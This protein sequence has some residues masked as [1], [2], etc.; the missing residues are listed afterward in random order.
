M[1]T[2]DDSAFADVA[3]VN[4]CRSPDKAACALRFRA[5]LLRAGQSRETSPHPL[6]IVG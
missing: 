4:K 6:N 2:G 1:N 5:A 3:P